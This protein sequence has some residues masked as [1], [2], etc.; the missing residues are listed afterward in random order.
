VCPVLAGCLLQVIK[1]IEAIEKLK[2]E[3]GC[4]PTIKDVVGKTPESEWFYMSTS[5][6]RSCQVC[7][8]LAGV[9]L[10]SVLLGTLLYTPHVLCRLVASL[11]KSAESD[12]ARQPSQSTHGDQ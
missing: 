2:A 1:L 11:R 8:L 7:S 6:W 12:C 4:P 3:V 9:H 5:K 10:S